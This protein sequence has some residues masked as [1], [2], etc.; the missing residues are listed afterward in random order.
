METTLKKNY[1]SDAPCRVGTY[2]SGA[3]TDMY[4]HAPRSNICKL[5]QKN[6]QILG[7]DHK[8]QQIDVRKIGSRCL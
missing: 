8:I 5:I 1:T 2:R 4:L 3:C 7:P 6:L